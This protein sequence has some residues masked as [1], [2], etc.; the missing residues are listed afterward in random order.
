[1]QTIGRVH[2]IISWALNQANAFLIVWRLNMIFIHVVQ[3]VDNSLNFHFVDKNEVRLEYERVSIIL[4]F[5]IFN[6]WIATLKWGQ[7]LWVALRRVGMF[8]F[9]FKY[10]KQWYSHYY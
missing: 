7:F 8:A 4:P 5:Y 9:I 1:M 6:H 3:D 2:I 10:P